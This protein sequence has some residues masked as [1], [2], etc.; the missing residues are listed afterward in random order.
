[1]IIGYKTHV[2]NVFH[3]FSEIFTFTQ[4]K[5][6]KKIPKEKLFYRTFKISFLIPTIHMCELN[7][8]RKYFSRI[9]ILENVIGFSLFP[10]RNLFLLWECHISLWDITF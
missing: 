10:V 8:C 3:M 7:S 5:N 2:I 4:R 6:E 1:M 9:K